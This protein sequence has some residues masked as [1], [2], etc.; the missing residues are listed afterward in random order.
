MSI[1]ASGFYNELPSINNIQIVN[2]VYTFDTVDGKT[3]LLKVNNSIYLD[4]KMNHSL[5]CLNQCREEGIKVHTHTKANC[6]EER[7]QSLTI[8]EA[9]IAIPL[10]HHEPIPYFHVRLA[11]DF[12]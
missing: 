4:E 8:P 6:N 5:L 7:A 11:G 3:I 10:L 9:N 2:M 12:L 1:T